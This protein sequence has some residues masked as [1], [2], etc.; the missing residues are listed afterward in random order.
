MEKGEKMRLIDRDELVEQFNG[1]PYGYRDRFPYGYPTV[2]A[3]AVVRCKD[4]KKRGTVYC[5]LDYCG[6]RKADN[7]YCADG[8][9]N[10]DESEN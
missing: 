6:Y 9:R 7:W 4:C 3:V 2:D 1:V 5:D 10:D 8:E